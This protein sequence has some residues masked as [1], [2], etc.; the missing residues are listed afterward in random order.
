MYRQPHITGWDSTH[1]DGEFEVGWYTDFA[2]GLDPARA[3]HQYSS[4]CCRTFQQTH[5][6]Q[7]HLSQRTDFPDATVRPLINTLTST[8]VPLTWCNLKDSPYTSKQLRH[9][10]NPFNNPQGECAEGYY[11]TTLGRTHPMT[12][13]LSVNQRPQR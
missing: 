6:Y 13:V 8:G 11:R 4:F 7:V 1:G 3:D 12:E 5:L 10:H 2:P 9:L